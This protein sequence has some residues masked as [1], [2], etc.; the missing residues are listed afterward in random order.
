LETTLTYETALGDRT[1]RGAEAELIGSGTWQLV[2][3]ILTMNSTEDGVQ[4]G[5][6]LFDQMT[7]QQQIVLLD[8]VLTCLLDPSVPSPPRTALLDATIAAIYQQLRARVEG[9]IYTERTSPEAEDGDTLQRQDVLWALLEHDPDRN[10]PDAEC[11]V[12]ET[13]ELALE[14][15]QDRVLADQD[16]A[17]DDL[18]MDLPPDEGRALKEVMGISG[19]Y[20]ID[21][22]PEAIDQQARQS[23]ANIIERLTGDRPTQFH[24]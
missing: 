1:L 6:V 7:W 18:T 2:D 16:W 8:R 4:L 17:M 24:F 11:G 10:W 3:D 19:D 15:L 23:W 13:W 5:I 21:V 20:F 14:S 9:E 22:P 12:M